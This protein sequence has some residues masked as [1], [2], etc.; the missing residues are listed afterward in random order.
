MQQPPGQEAQE[1][2]STP[3]EA[4]G[5]RIKAPRPSLPKHRAFPPIRE[6]PEG[7]RAFEPPCVGRPLR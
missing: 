6:P 5:S 1:T 4:A 2:H 3:L 7:S